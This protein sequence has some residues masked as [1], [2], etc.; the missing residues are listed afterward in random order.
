MNELNDPS[1]ENTK[2][3]MLALIMQKTLKQLGQQTVQMVLSEE[4]SLFSDKGKEALL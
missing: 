4:E 3:E 1:G 2:R